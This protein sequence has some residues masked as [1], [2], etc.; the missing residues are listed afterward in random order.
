[1]N[2]EEAERYARHL[3]LREIGAK[4]QERLKNSKVLVIGAGGLGSAALYYLAVAGV[5]TI[6]IV[7]PDCVELHN[8][9]RQILHTSARVG[10]KKTDSAEQALKELNRDIRI[11]KYPIRADAENLPELLSGYDFVLDCVDRFETKFLIN[12]ACVLNK[13]PY[14]HAGVV[15]FG[16]QVMTFVPGKG[17]CLR[18]LLGHPPEGSTCAQVGIVGAAAGVIGS[19]QALE[20]IKY[21]VGAGQLLTGRV[22]SL[23][24]L[25]WNIRVTEFLSPNP[26]CAVC[27]THPTITSL[28][29][30]RAEYGE[31]CFGGEL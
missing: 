1:M 15:R 8:L 2:G 16:G 27:G 17:P 22:L 19:I 7:D 28:P 18:C 13:K 9:Q 12:D 21:L 31:I 23:D 24:G 30:N 10:R 3:I 6:G 26:D 5:G 4:G 29:E 25:T 14:C 11:L 20:A